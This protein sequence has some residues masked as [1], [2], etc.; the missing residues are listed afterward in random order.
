MSQRVGSNSESDDLIQ[1]E[2]DVRIDDNIPDSLGLE[3]PISIGAKVAD[4][5]VIYEKNITLTRTG[6]EKPDLEMTATYN[7]ALSTS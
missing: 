7:S 1:I 6:Y 2:V 4:Y 5:I 3:F